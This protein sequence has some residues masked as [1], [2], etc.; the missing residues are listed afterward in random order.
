MFEAIVCRWEYELVRFIL[1]EG[2][3]G[4]RVVVQF[5]FD[6]RK[7]VGWKERVGSTARPLDAWLR[8]RT[9]FPISTDGSA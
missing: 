4:L 6:R 5:L 2:F 9:N 8:H 1:S 3:V 7:E